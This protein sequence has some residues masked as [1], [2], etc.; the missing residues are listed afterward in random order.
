M[1]SVLSLGVVCGAAVGLVL[2]LIGSGGS[3]FAVP[4]LLYV[5]GVG[6]PHLAIG[7]S[8]VA[9][10]LSAAANLAL[11]ARAGTVKWSCAALFASAGT[12]AAWGG[13]SL[14]KAIDGQLLL[15]FFG[16]MML[17]I[18]GIALRRRARPGRPE[19]RL[20]SSSFRSLG[21]RLAAS[22]LAVGAASGFFGI[23]GGFLAVPSMMFV[24]DMPIANAVGSSLLAVTAFGTTT[25]VNY[26][27]SG[28]VDWPIAGAFLAGG[29][30]GGLIGTRLALSWSRRRG[31]LSTVFALVVILVGLYV[32]A[33]A[34][35]Q[36]IGSMSFAQNSSVHAPAVHRIR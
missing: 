2:G 5:V 17:M 13:S 20:D 9:V 29:I 11:H 27:A 30:G 14:G 18:G 16:L 19:V 23:G 24:T 1:L 22:G 25:A 10:A 26:A 4:L 6:S 8:A 36:L 3:I 31:L 32:I 35:T 7:T 33:R 34:S 28:L 21:P 12:I 15:A